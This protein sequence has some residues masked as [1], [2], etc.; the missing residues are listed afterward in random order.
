MRDTMP[1][2]FRL[3]LN[4]DA[5]ARTIRR[6]YAR[7]LKLIDQE[8]DAAGFQELR[9]AYEAALHWADYR[10]REPAPAPL[11]PAPPIVNFGMPRTPVTLG[12]IQRADAAPR[13]AP[14]SVPGG[15]PRLCAEQ[16]FRTF[17]AAV[18]ALQRDHP[19]QHLPRW[20]ATLQHSLEDEQLLNLTARTLF[21]SHIAQLLA[22]GWRPGHEMLFAAAIEV[23]HWS[24][25]QRRLLQLGAAGSRINQAIK[26]MS[27]LDTL[28][29]SQQMNHRTAM[30]LLRTASEPTTQQLRDAMPYVE[31]LMSYFPVWMSLMVDL[32]TVAQWRGRYESLPAGKK[33]PEAKANTGASSPWTTWITVVFILNMVRIVFSNYSAPSAPPQ[34]IPA[35]IPS[36]LVIPAPQLSPYQ[37]KLI[38]ARIPRLPV[39]APGTGPHQANFRVELD[40]NGGIYLL[41]MLSTSGSSI[42]DYAV[43]KAIRESAPFP[44]ETPR[45]F[46][47]SLTEPT[48]P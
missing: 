40:E 5:D 47:V 1:F 11:Q 32:E 46:E 45:K 9:E 33:K 23:F 26:E 38:E 39:S 41:V 20:Q 25:D 3:G 24:D 2:L 27:G 16:A 29:E 12:K 44:Q 30:A 10:H 28:P 15:D 31:N 7:E 37:M 8:R 21:E 42:Y 36:S 17:A 48:N 14:A 13:H 43:S 19:G 22:G 35:S 34:A 6:A 18:A 4:D